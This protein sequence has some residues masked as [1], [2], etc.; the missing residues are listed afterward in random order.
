MYL[1]KV[2][3]RK[4]CIKKIFFPG[5]FKVNAENRRILIKDPDSDP[6]QDPLVRGMDQKCHGSATLV[7]TY[8][9]FDNYIL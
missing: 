3:S 8:L 4:N 1:K 9:E 7:R 5:I 2:L 6:N